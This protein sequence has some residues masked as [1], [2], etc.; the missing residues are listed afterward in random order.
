MIKRVL[1]V[2]NITLMLM[3]S[4]V[5]QAAVT[6]ID[7]IAV[8]VNDDIIMKSQV[9]DRLQQVYRNYQRQG[10]TPPD[11]DILIRQVVEQLILESIQLQL[12]DLAGVRIDDTTLNST[13]LRVAQQNNMDLDQFR[14]ALEADGTDY[15]QFRNQ[16]RN[17]MIIQQV[18]EG[19][20]S[21][22][23]E[24]TD[25]EIASYLA[26]EEGQQQT[27][28]NY[29]LSHILVQVPESASADEVQ[30]YQAKA[31]QLYQQLQQG[32]DF[33]ELAKAYSDGSN[34]ADGGQ[35]GWR[36]DS[37]LPSIFAGELPS[38]QVGDITPPFRSSN[39]FHILKLTDKTG[40]DSYLVTQYHVRH[41]LIEESQ[42]RTDEEAKEFI[43]QLRERIFN[44]EDFGELASKYSDDG[45]SLADGG[46]LGWMNPNDLVP[47]FREVMIKTPLDELSE[48]FKSQFGWHILEVLGKRDQD[49]GQLVKKN[50]AYQAIFE[51]KFDEEADLW[52]SEQ[53]EEAY[54]D[55]KIY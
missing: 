2:F 26:S 11:E 40:G 14:Q 19:Y 15:N 39:G 34:A 10:A 21:S 17:E 30:Q 5:T 55:I 33:G 45:G 37:Q 12:G 36:K 7:S 43:T 24:V 44:G 29:Q 9:D 16:I 3:V 53:R 27:E 25:Q 1:T 54:V 42:I 51:R 49:L 20:V 23:I 52:L 4:L 32:A 13:I 47:A 28:A 48:P 46:D 18:R 31:N 6:P 35:L 38:L 8:V 41:I 22:R 50:Q